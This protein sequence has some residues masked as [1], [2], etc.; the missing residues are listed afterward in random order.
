MPKIGFTGGKRLVNIW[1][2]RDKDTRKVDYIQFGAVAGMDLNAGLTQVLQDG[3]N[4]YLHGA[5]RVA[6]GG[7]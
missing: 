1:L 6:Q 4:T 5:G 3:T 7:R 2:F